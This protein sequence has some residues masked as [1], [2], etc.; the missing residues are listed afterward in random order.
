MESFIPKV[1]L[2]GGFFYITLALIIVIS[3]FLNNQFKSRGFLI[4]LVIGMFF[5]VLTS[6][7][8]ITKDLEEIKLF[9]RN[10]REKIKNSTFNQFFFASQIRETLNPQ[11]NNCVFW[12]WDVATKYLIQESYPLKLKTVWDIES[13]KKCDF[14]VSQFRPRPELNLTPFVTFE[15][16]FIYEIQK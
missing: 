3:S 11:D 7:S 15:N 4:I 16:S 2:L 1:L 13:A 12:S 9:F 10:D 5:T 14:V 8:Q 6:I